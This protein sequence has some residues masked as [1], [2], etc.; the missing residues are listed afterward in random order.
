M[1]LTPSQIEYLKAAAK[2]PTRLSFIIWELGTKQTGDAL[3]RR[4]YLDRIR[5]FP[6]MYRISDAGRTAL[7]LEPQEVSDV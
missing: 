7:E 6:P 3:F 1:T 5:E 2:L 4:R